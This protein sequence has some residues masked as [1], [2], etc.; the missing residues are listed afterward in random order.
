MDGNLIGALFYL[1]SRSLLNLLGSRLRRL[2]QPKYLAGALMGMAYLY[3]VFGRN[4]AA[5]RRPGGPLPDLADVHSV[6]PAVGAA[7]TLGFILLCWV[8]RR[9]RASLGFSEAEIAFLFPAPTTRRALVHYRIISTALASLFTAVLLGAMSARAQWMP[10]NFLMRALAWWLLFGTL[11]LHTIG[12]GFTLTRCMDRGWSAL[13]CQ[14]VACVVV[15][16]LVGAPLA[17][18]FHAPPLDADAWASVL[19]TGP[20][21]WLL[22][23]FQ[24]LIAP[25]LAADADSFF[26]AL[27]PALL[28]YLAHY[29]W[30]LQVQVGF[31]DGS[32]ARAEKRAAVAAAMRAGNWRLGSGRQKARSAPFE[33]ARVHRPELAFLWKNL[34]STA[35]YLRPRNA[36]IVAA[37]IVGGSL[38]AGDS[39]FFGTLRPVLGMV[40]AVIAAYTLVLGPL[41]A[42][43]DFRSDLAN[44]D[45]LKTYPLRG[46][47]VMLGEM[48]APAAILTG[49]V[50]LML[51]AAAMLLPVHASKTLVLTPALRAGLALALGLLAPLL[52]MVQLLILNTAAVVFP[53]W[54]PVSGQAQQGIDAMG[55]R[56]LFLVAQVLAMVVM[57]FPAAFVGALGFAVARWLAGLAIGTAAGVLLGAAVL[58]VELGLAIAWLGGR[59]EQL[60]V[61]KELRP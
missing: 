29:V 39:G 24:L 36:L 57:L 22:W 35:S 46:W 14:L 1:R 45:M 53:A 38:W 19:R 23:P 2:R 58:V 6:M 10:G 60:D 13:R 5:R 61:S 43:Q 49:I 55:Q 51:L 27:L 9:Q 20:I 32:I 52:C 12:S 50:W 28:I 31:E 21:A 59:F 11:S 42:R 15:A 41:L 26:I 34:L 44:T 33:L 37:L 47:Q 7:I 30:V 25:L 16:V 54:Q 8:L 4:F 48:L 17:W 56:M 3:F 18:L 40:A